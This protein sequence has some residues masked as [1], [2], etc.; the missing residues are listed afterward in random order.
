MVDKFDDILNEN[1]CY[2]MSGGTVKVSPAKY[3]TV[4]NEYCIVFEKN[5]EI[6]LIDD[7]GTVAGS[8][9]ESPNSFEFVPI[10]DV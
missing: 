4:K 7:D 8:A 10:P 9:Q 2:L 5:S 3:A 1:S 6:E